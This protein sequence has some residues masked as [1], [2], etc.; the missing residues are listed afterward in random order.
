MIETALYIAL[1]FF[2]ASILALAALP[3]IWARAVRLTR[4]ALEA[5]NPIS[6]ARAA[7]AKDALRA[8]HAIAIRHMEVRLQ[9]MTE[10]LAKN[11]AARSISEAQ[12]AEL[13][14]ELS[15]VQIKSARDRKNM[16]Q[17]ATR[18]LRKARSSETIPFSAED[19]INADPIQ[20]ADGQADTAQ[21][22][23]TTQP[24][25]QPTSAEIIPLNN[26][27]AAEKTKELDEELK[28]GDAAVGPITPVDTSDLQD[29]DNP[30]A[31]L[32]TLISKQVSEMTAEAETKHQPTSPAEAA[33]LASQS[34][35]KLKSRYSSLEKERDQLKQELQLEKAANDKPN[36]R[37][38]KNPNIKSP[39][40]MKSLETDLEAAKT[41][42]EKLTKQLEERVQSTSN[43]EEAVD[44]R[45]ELKDLAAQI[46]AKAIAENPPLS[47]KYDEVLK[48]LGMIAGGAPKPQT[49]KRK[50]RTATKTT[51]PRARKT[52]TPKSSP[53]AKPEKPASAS[54]ADRDLAERIADARKTSSS[55]G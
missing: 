30:L 3:F 21:S 35:T 2:L 31:E 24:T 15:V 28:D 40:Q 10:K 55:R 49:P 52:T 42:I 39:E 8:Q 19:R 23:T 1:G 4:K 51:K 12:L 13:K 26:Q 41:T 5:S 48:D 11:A 46:T 53:P 16:A 29:T 38:T 17:K 50:P 36:K 20:E 44:L 7:M 14:E 9:N 54:P 43:I 22:E 6:Y 47:E 25:Q 27:A 32:A 18:F 45:N 37:T 33:E 34:F